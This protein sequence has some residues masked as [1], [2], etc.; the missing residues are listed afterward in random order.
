VKKN[1]KSYYQILG[2][3]PD[4]SASDIKR[5]YRDI[6]KEQHPDV[7]QHHKSKKQLEQET[8]EML[9]INEA[10]ETLRDKKRRTEY[11][12]IIGVT[13]SVKA[14]YQFKKNNEDEAR[15]IF[16]AKVFNPSRSAISRVLTNYGKQLKKLSQDPFDDELVEEFSSYL[17]DIEQALRKAS[18]LFA[19]NQAPTTLEPAAHMMRH[20]IAQAAD[21]LEE[22]RRFCQNYDYDHL[23]TAEN[24]FKIAFD[25]ARQAYALTKQV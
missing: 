21:G 11:D 5:A 14:P 8:E 13:I 4:A 2:L 16:L 20:C 12:I 15:E 22:T 10:Y 19:G 23:S 18:A 17:D 3:K 24:L 6:V 25:L 1:H 7:G 9:L